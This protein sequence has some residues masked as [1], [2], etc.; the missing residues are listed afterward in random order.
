MPTESC[1]H[2]KRARRTLERRHH[3]ELTMRNIYVSAMENVETELFGKHIRPS[4]L[5]TNNEVSTFYHMSQKKSLVFFPLFL[6][7]FFTFSFHPMHQL[8]KVKIN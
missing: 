2:R 8:F 5:A 1:K 3:H 4:E 7:V 6:N